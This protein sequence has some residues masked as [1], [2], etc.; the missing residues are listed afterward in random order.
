M[1]QAPRRI[2]LREF[3][4]RE[5]PRSDLTEETGEAIFETY[6]AQIEVEFPSPR[7]AHRWSL[8]PKGWVGQLPVND[9]L[10]LVLAPK[11]PIGNLFG[12]LEYAYNLQS[13]QFL[14]GDVQVAS[15]DD[16]YERLAH[17]L[18]KRVI[19]RT[20]R[21][22]YLTYVNR[23]DRLPYLTGRMNLNETLRRPWSPDLACIYQEHTADIDDNRILA[24]TLSTILHS[25][26]CTHR[27]VSTIRH[28]YH[29]L[30]TAVDV[31]PCPAQACANRLY[32]RLN[33]DYRPMHALSRFF[34]EHTGP[35]HQVGNRTVIPF[36][37]DMAR[38]YERFVAEWL[39]AYLPPDLH[40]KRQDRV[41]IDGTTGLRVD[42]DLT[43]YD[44]RTGTTLCV[45]DTKYKSA[46]SPSTDDL[47]QVVAYAE[48][49]D[50]QQAMLIYP[51]PVA[52][53]TLWGAKRVRALTFPVDGNLEAAGQAFLSSL[54]SALHR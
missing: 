16:L 8:K 1:S 40:L 5:L 48:L 45:M 36:L 27:T 18:A 13:F 46:A 21:G 39:A 29:A 4:E 53:D 47:Q 38:L 23:S 12:M 10:T 24:W 35:T 22:L 11:T 54:L 37:V 31:K 52:L 19:D 32:H 2:T 6:G 41:V 26:V 7:T 49:K 25:H 20:R 14:Q 15:L 50:T 17:I 34:L 43:L 33:E 9:D 30:R 3:E 44:A 51:V 28:A 42:I